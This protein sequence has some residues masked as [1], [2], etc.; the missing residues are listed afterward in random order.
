VPVAYRGDWA[1][2]EP[3]TSWNGDWV[4]T[5]EKGR[6]V[7]VSDVANPLLGTARLAPWDGE[8][9]DLLP[10]DLPAEDRRGSLLAFREAVLTG[11]PA[12]TRAEDNLWSLAAV[13]ACVASIES[14]APVDLAALVGR[15][16]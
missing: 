2:H 15:S 9:R 16:A 7:W 6:L 13:T 1:T 5:G 11:E 4:I 3:E 14:G 8:P 12:E 10:A